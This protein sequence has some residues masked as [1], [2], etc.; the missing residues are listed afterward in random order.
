MK[1]RLKFFFSLCL[2]LVAAFLLSFSVAARAGGGGG[3]GGGGGHSITSVHSGA[4][5]NQ[6]SWTTLLYAVL[7]NGTLIVILFHRDI[8]FYFKLHRKGFESRKT[9]AELNKRDAFFDYSNFRKTVEDTFYKVQDA[10]GERDQELDKAFLSQ[11][12]YEQFCTKT[13]E[14]K[15]R[16]EKDILRDIHLLDVIPVDVEDFPDS[17]VDFIWVYIKAKMADY[18]IDEQSRR[19]ISGSKNIKS[20]VEYWKFIKEDGRWVLDEI[21]QK[22][23]VKLDSI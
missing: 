7:I 15:V 5:G 19:V 9:M 4:S 12:L 2:V 17:N 22:D 8:L 1:K 11:S 16:H 21:K 14:M 10:W 3:G 6:V 18:V 23:E 20:F 13:A